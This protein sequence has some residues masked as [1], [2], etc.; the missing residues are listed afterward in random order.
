MP[1]TDVSDA[2]D[3]LAW[4]VSTLQSHR[5]A[6]LW[7]LE[8]VPEHDARRPLT[9]TGTNLLG[10]VKHLAYVEFGYWGPTFGREVTASLPAW[11]DDAS[12]NDD[13]YAFADES[14][15]DVVALYRAAWTFGD[16]TVARGLGHLGRVPWWPE[17]RARVDVRLVLGH[18]IA[19]TARHAGHADILREQLDGSV[20][21]FLGRENLPKED[22]TWWRDYLGRVEAAADAHR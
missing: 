9:P 12:P 14:R 13:M 15:E 7:K 17:E 2:P 19:E 21:R 16:E 11:D 3:H 1:S 4:L 10:L 18:L 20:G 5:D 6:V 22:A 8:G